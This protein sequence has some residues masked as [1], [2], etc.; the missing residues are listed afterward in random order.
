MGPL[1]LDNDKWIFVC[2][3]NHRNTLEY[4]I[5]VY[6]IGKIV[7]TIFTIFAQKNPICVT[8]LRV[9]KILVKIR[10]LAE[11]LRHV[12]FLMTYTLRVRVQLAFRPLDLD[13]LTDLD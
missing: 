13:G 1:L 2:V 12:F 4:S 10:S 11:I 8:N 6:K 7:F 3:F 5:L 9:L